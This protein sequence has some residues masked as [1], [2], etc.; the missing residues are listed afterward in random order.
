MTDPTGPA[1]HTLRWYSE[2]LRASVAGT[3]VA[4][5]RGGS[6][7]P[8]LF[9]HGHWLTR[10]WTPFHQQLADR[11]D[12]FAPE[13]PG[14]GDS[15]AA[16]E[17]TTRPDMVLL[18]RAMLDELGLDGVHVVGYGL[19]G[20][21]AA[22]F[23]VWAPDRVRSLAVIAP[24]GLRVPGHPLADVFI[25]NPSTYTE[26]YFSA[27]SSADEQ[28]GDLVPGVGTPADGGPEEFAHR[29]GELGAAAA[30][31]WAPRYDL[32]L[33]T[34]LPRLAVPALVVGAA[35][36][37][38]VP[39]AHVDAWAALLGAKRTTIQSAGH[40]VLVEAPDTTVAAIA[41]FVEE[42]A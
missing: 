10:R 22:D 11:V 18:L 21:L 32:R 36:D 37:R 17:F 42:N 4:Y 8:V 9:L 12:L 2:P 13:L 19:G 16:T 38:I 7:E 39:A 6:G 14:F 15:P 34:R 26:R 30:L 33:E 29:Y 3:T 24:F 25:M 20:W 35:D 1:V 5:R 31:M 27:A 40:A 28:F 23:A 41:D